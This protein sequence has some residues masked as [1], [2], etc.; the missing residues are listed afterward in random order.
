MIVFFRNILGLG[1]PRPNLPLL[2]IPSSLVKL[3]V[4]VIV[5]PILSPVISSFEMSL[6]SH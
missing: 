6:V 5:D 4:G 2:K 3:V 1:G